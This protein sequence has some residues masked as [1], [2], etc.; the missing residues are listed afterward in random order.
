MYW[1]QLSHFDI[2]DPAATLPSLR[3]ADEHAEASCWR[4][5]SHINLIHDIILCY[6]CYIRNTSSYSRTSTYSRD[7]YVESNTHFLLNT[8]K[9]QVGQSGECDNCNIS[10]GISRSAYECEDCTAVLE[11]LN[12]QKIIFSAHELETRPSDDSDDAH[13]VTFNVDAF[14]YLDRQE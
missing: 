5:I 3:I 7:Y 6:R 14:R 10:L 12:Q 13:T 9:F 11:H 8:S 4:I 2:P 1:H